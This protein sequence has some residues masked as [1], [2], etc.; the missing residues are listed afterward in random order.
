MV[1]WVLYLGLHGQV[2][3][4]LR[5]AW[6]G[7][8]YV[9]WSALSG[10]GYVLDLHGQ[11]SSVLR[12]AWSGRGYVPRSAWSGGLGAEVCM[13]RWVLYLGLHGQVGVMYLGLHGQ[14]G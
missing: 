3:S 5:S 14:V 10:R 4:V 9:P 2:G 8:G 11:V 7:R 13:V 12:S 6:P 1:S